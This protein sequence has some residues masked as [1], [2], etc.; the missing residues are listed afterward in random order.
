VP[1]ERTGS[2]PY[3]DLARERGLNYGDVLA[4]ADLISHNPGRA[5]TVT[6]LRAARSLSPADQ[7]A[8]NLVVVECA[9]R[10]WR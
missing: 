9:N 10:G 5:V 6:M 3:L 2:Y 1:T 8:I 7:G 4:F